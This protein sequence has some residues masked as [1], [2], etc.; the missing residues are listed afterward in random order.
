LLKTIKNFL[1]R[2][3]VYLLF[4][5]L[6]KT[7]RIKIIGKDNYENL[8]K[9]KK[10]FIFIVWHGRMFLPVYLHRNEGIKPLISLSQNGEIASQIVK[11]LGYYPIRGS[12]SRGGKGALKEMCEEL[13]N[14]AELAIIPD[15]PKGPRRIL[16]PGC[17]YLAQKTGAYLVPISYSCSRKIFLKSWDKF[18]LFPPFSKCIVLYGKPIKV[19]KNL[20][21][22]ELENIREKIEE[23]LIE[24]DNQADSYFNE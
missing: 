24:L 3:I 16:K 15:G 18:L 14:Y 20:N 5:I 4:S 2:I 10:S 11:L 23:I 9:Q 7:A 22:K 21:K 6:G 19:K 1:F 13:E 8:R 12:S 17:I